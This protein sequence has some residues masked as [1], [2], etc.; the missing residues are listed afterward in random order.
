ME[1]QETGSQDSSQAAVFNQSRI[2]SF[3]L[4]KYAFLIELRK[5]APA[6]KML[7]PGKMK[8]AW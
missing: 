2:T 4:E 3:Q 6:E 8:K 1:N 7:P 5:E